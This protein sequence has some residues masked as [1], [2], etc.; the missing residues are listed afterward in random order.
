MW[1]HYAEKHEGLCLGFVIPDN[2]TLHVN[3]VDERLSPE[4]LFRGKEQ[5]RVNAMEETLCTKFSH[6]KYEEEVRFFPIL[7]KL[8]QIGN[9]YFFHFSH[10]LEL[11]EVV[12]GIEAKQCR[13]K[14]EH[15]LQ[16]YETHVDLFQAKAAF[17]RFEV[18]RER[19]SGN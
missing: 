15:A 17:T 9:H 11:K 3:Y 4:P 10:Q 7:S 12:M 6:W 13:K 14:V 18:E 16:D 8:E 2:R 1:S 19:L 5:E